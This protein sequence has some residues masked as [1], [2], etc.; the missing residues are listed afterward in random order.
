MIVISITPQLSLRS[1]WIRVI[2]QAIQ[3]LKV[4]V[5]TDLSSI[6][7]LLLS[8]QLLIISQVNLWMRRRET[9]HQ[10][11]QTP[12]SKRLSLCSKKKERKTRNFLINT[13]MLLKALNSIKWRKIQVHNK[14]QHYLKDKVHRKSLKISLLTYLIRTITLKH[15]KIC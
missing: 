2:I 5:K 7:S 3:D 1:Q 4:E 14:L 9:I 13:T 6:L 8:L 10:L 12:F 15:Q 11:V